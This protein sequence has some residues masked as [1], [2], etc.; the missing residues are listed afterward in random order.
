MEDQELIQ[1]A[2]EA[3]T[4][5]YEADN[6]AVILMQKIAELAIKDP[7]SYETAKNLLMKM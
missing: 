1:Q 2:S 5:W 4:K 7:S 6:D 3:L